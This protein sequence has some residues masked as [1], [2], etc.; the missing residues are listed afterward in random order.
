MSTV[1][2]AWGGAVAVMAVSDP[3]VKLLAGT[4]PKKTAKAPVKALPVMATAVPPAEVPVFGVTS[5]TA[6]TAARV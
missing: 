4:V 6:G 1:P 5:V 3:T 2:A